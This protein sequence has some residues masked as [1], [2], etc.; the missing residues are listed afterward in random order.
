MITLIR[1]SLIFKV[2]DGIH[3][4]RFQE[5]KDRLFLIGKNGNGLRG[6]GYQ[7]NAVQIHM[8]RQNAVFFRSQVSFCDAPS[9][10]TVCIWQNVSAKVRQKEWTDFSR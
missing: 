8:E 10:S 9:G 4:F 5:Y 7:V 1:D 6:C 3:A 2:E